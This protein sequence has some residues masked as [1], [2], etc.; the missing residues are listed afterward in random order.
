MKNLLA[1]LFIF[2][3]AHELVGQGLSPVYLPKGRYA[4]RVFN[5]YGT[6]EI[7]SSARLTY[8]GDKEVTPLR[9][10]GFFNLNSTF[11]F[12]FGKYVGLYTG[13]GVRNIGMVYHTDS[14]KYKYRTYNLFVP[15]GLKLGNLKHGIFLNIGGEF[16]YAFNYREKKFTN[17]FKK[18]DKYNKFGSEA[19]PSIQWIAFAGLR[20]KILGLK[21]GY[22]FNNYLNPNYVRNGIKRHAGFHAT[23]MFIAVTIDFATLRVNRGPIIGYYKEFKRKRQNIP[24]K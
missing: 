3:F 12:E 22:V 2:L 13:L 15:L 18:I 19:T 21:F 20:Y 6:E 14:M 9:Y 16:N 5:E 23:L 11:H 17:R 7:F 10:S 24:L 1:I 8:Y 4:A